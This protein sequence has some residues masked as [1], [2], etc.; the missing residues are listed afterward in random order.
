MQAQN[1][2]NKL[3]KIT[4]QV[5]NFKTQGLDKINTVT[6]QMVQKQDQIRSVVSPVL[7]LPDPNSVT[8]H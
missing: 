8:I 7:G 6:N 1:M 3:N 2:G 4:N 5:H